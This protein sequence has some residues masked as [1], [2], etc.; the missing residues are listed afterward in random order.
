LNV[1][2]LHCC[3]CWS[4]AVLLIVM[5]LQPLKL[6]GL[7][8]SVNLQHI[9]WKRCDDKFFVNISPNWS[10][11]QINRT[12]NFFVATCSRT[13]WKSNSICFVLTWKTGFAVRN[14]APKLSHQRTGAYEHW[15]PSS[16][17]RDYSQ[18]NLA[19]AIAKLRY[20]ASIDERDTIACFLEDKDTKLDIR[21][22]A[23][24][25]VDFLSSGQP[26]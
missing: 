22:T 18:I 15:I 6:N 26:A 16:E 7:E 17:S 14:V 25:V 9:S 1:A 10:A 4:R 5:F 20:S 19:V 23:K 3:L 13:K 24:P 8:D 12:I 2:L 11:E 21:N